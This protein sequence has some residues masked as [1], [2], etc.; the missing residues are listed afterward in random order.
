MACY[1]AQ[2]SEIVS[3]ADFQL[4]PPPPLPLKGKGAVE[5]EMEQ[6]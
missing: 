2:L 5:K 4:P 6:N 1:V 3:Y